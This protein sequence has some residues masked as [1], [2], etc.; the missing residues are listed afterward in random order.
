MERDTE[1]RRAE[2]LDR[3]WD[4]VLSGRQQDVPPD[5]D[6]TPAKLIHQLQAL[7]KTPGQEEARGR[8]WERLTHR[9]RGDLE[10][11]SMATTKV[12][13]SLA[14]AM[15]MNGRIDTFPGARPHGAPARPHRMATQFA[16]AV[17]AETA[18]HAP[19]LPARSTCAA[20]SERTVISPLNT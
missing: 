4:A 17:P 8:I 19:S 9:S 3:Y 12:L 10:D 14:P 1:R 7:D 18:C 20:L 11:M 13:P 15:G 6:E 2:A 5:V 16:T